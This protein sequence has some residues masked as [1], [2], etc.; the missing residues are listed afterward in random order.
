MRTVL[1]ISINTIARISLIINFFDTVQK[2]LMHSISKLGIIFQLK[3]L[4]GTFTV[5]YDT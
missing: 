5:K 1:S 4:K 3:V 2:I